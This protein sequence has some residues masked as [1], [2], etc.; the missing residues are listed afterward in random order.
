MHT[1]TPK[2]NSQKLY[3]KVSCSRKK[4][5]ETKQSFC[6]Y[7]IFTVLEQVQPVSAPCKLILV[8]RRDQSKKL[9][10]WLFSY[11]LFLNL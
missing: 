8:H 10:E 5:Y 3:F 6:V 7:H 9:P 1:H 11:S 4:G 2:V